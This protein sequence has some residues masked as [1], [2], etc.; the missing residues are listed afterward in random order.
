MIEGTNPPV[1]LTS[2]GNTTR[3][4]ISDD[5]SKVAFIRRVGPDQKPE[6]RSIN[7][8]GTGEI[9]LLTAAQIDALYPLD[10]AFTHNDIA[11]IAFV[12]GT[13][14]LMFNT[15]AVATGPGLFKYNDVALLD[16]DTGSLS[17]ILAPGDGGDFTLA[18]NGNQMALVR[19]ADISLADV[20]GSNLHSNLI[21]YTPVITYS[22]FQYYAQ[23]VWMPN[24]NAFGVAIPS[25]DPMAPGKNG[26]V[27]R[28]PA[29]G[30][31]ALN[32]STISGDFYFAQAFSSPVL[33]PSLQ[34]VAFLRDTGTPNV[35][36]LYLADA[37]GGGQTVYATG[38]IQW[39]G[40]SPDSLH[41]VYSLGG[42][43][44]LQLGTD[45]GASSSIGSCISLRW[46]DDT[47]YLCL[48]G[49]LGSW[50]LMTGQVGGGLNAI[51]S[52]AGDFISY[53]FDA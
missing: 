47:R 14:H 53:D 37:N 44:N 48:S 5:G 20:D 15:R 21:T 41:F 34:R 23:P 22:E 16:A 27:W 32:L 43:M 26:F 50:T 38:D 51:V 1:Q 19:P 13:H 33:S 8:D 25:S 29:D 35:K 49:S 46:V 3:V 40:W 2:G 28:I 42:P 30:S 10:P 12:P 17:T 45:G 36:D 39:K 9:T 6:I 31:A 24:S 52:P 4:L 7:T 11:N 18:P